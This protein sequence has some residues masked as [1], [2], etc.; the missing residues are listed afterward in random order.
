[1]ADAR[2]DWCAGYEN[3][4]RHGES[5][6]SLSPT[7][8]SAYHGGRHDV[9][10]S[11]TCAP[12]LCQRP[13][14]FLAAARTA[15][16]CSSVRTAQVGATATTSRRCYSTEYVTA[17]F[18]IGH[19]LLGGTMTHASLHLSR[20]CGSILG[21]HA[22]PAPIRGTERGVLCCLPGRS[23]RRHSSCSRTR[24]SR[25]SVRS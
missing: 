16:A 10:D 23:P 6:A 24:R 18:Q 3:G 2:S 11:R 22:A 17:M 8:S 12:V 14:P 19:L 15:T 9:A 20:Q 25:P 13:M 4:H 7:A 5:P 21:P 1:M